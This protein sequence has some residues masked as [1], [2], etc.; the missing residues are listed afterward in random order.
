M[1]GSVRSTIAAHE[2]SALLARQP[3][4]RRLGAA[5]VRGHRLRHG[6]RKPA[7]ER[8]GD[9]RARRLG[10]EPHELPL[11][12]GEVPARK[13]IGLEH[14]R[15]A[16]ELARA[17]RRATRPAP[18]ARSRRSGSTA[19][20]PCDGMASGLR[21]GPRARPRA[22]RRT[23]ACGTSRREPAARAPGVVGTTEWPKAR[24]ISR[25]APSLPVL[26][27]DSPPVA[28]TTRATSCSPRDVRTRYPAP[29]RSDLEH[30]LAGQQPDP[31]PLDL[32]E[33][34][35][36][37]DL[38]PVRVREQLAVLFLVKRHADLAEERDRL[39]HA[40]RAQHALDEVPRRAVE[41]ALGDDAVGD[42]AARA[43]AHQ[44][45]GPGPLRPLKEKDGPAH[46][47]TR[48]EDGRS[49]AGGART[50]DADH[51]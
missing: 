7:R 40:E 42:V 20:S 37:H 29:L 17:D 11:D 19:A 24:A 10:G 47:A 18:R 50:D 32:V 48:R 45:L 49:Q 34:R 33:Q 15:A 13:E 22:R 44:D 26:G 27:S 38:G 6:L 4:E 1:T 41:V 46:S 8:A 51:G 12:P 3:A 30:T 16:L 2:R 31:A 35:L 39:V 14:R 21:R 5:G 23:A 25:P 28:R 43:A 36:Q 9:A